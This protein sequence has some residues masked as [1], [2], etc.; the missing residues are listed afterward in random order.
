M[1]WPTPEIRLKS[2]TMQRRRGERRRRTITKYDMKGK[3]TETI[4]YDREKTIME[5]RGGGDESWD[6]YCQCLVVDLVMRGCD[7]LVAHD[8]VKRD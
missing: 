2:G 1:A 6:R 7:T 8:R 3:G 5:G 4:P